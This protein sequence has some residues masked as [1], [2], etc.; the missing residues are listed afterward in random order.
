MGRTLQKKKNKSSLPRATQKP[1]SK[2]LNLKGNPIVAKNWSKTET[3]SQNY[4]RL[5]LVSKLNTRAGGVEITTSDLAARRKSA[6]GFH[7]GGA[8]E[9]RNP[10]KGTLGTGTVE[11]VRGQDGR[12]VSVVHGAEGE[13]GEGKVRRWAGRELVDELGSRDG[14]EE[15]E[16][17]QHDLY[18]PL[19]EEQGDG[20]GVVRELEMQAQ[21]LGKREKRKRKQSSREEEWVRGLVER[22]GD[23]VEAMARDRKRNPM[24]Q[25]VGDIGRRVR[26]WREARKES[27]EVG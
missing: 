6:A 18:I 22:Y 3:L 2:K 4:R 12:I 16:G 27:G 11:V 26:V 15:M 8:L 13:G 17:G 10:D 19:N 25:S 1:K 9:I 7:G 5:G 20:E 23:D 24:Q 21:E 14:E